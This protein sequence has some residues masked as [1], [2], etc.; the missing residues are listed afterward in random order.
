MHNP[1]LED[2]DKPTHASVKYVNPSQV[3]GESCKL[4]VHYIPPDDG[5]HARC[6][7]VRNPIAAHARC[8]KF[9]KASSAQNGRRR[10]PAT[11]DELY[12]QFHGR[13]PDKSYFVDVPGQDAYSNHPEL[14]QLGFLIRFIVGEEVELGGEY[15]DEV[16]DADWVNQIEFVPSI[17]KWHQWLED[18][19][20][21][22]AEAKAYLR[23]QRAPDVASEPNARQLYIVGGNQFLDD[24]RLIELG[25]DPEK[26]ICDLGNCYLIEYFTQKRFDKFEPTNY[27]HHFGEKTGVQPRLMYNRIYKGL[28][29]AGGEYVVKP[30]GIDN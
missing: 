7:G 24:K 17:A 20:P 30:A 12:K 27:W 2:E 14:A 19:E 15:G 18:D 11:A 6:E 16:K 29:L 4:C 10:N 26:D 23:Q 13:G 3:R 22:V 21:T 9:Q 28:F 5:E 1:E 25:A 8:D